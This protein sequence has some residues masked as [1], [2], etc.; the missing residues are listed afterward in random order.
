ADS[1]LRRDHD[2]GETLVFA[3]QRLSAQRR[4]RQGTQLAMPLR[5]ALFVRLRRWP[6]ALVLAAAG[7]SGDSAAR[8]YGR[9]APTRV[10]DEKVLC[11]EVHGFVRA[12]GRDTG[13]LAGS[14]EPE[15]VIEAPQTRACGFARAVGAGWHS[16]DSALVALRVDS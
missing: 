5:L 16:P 1:D 10:P 15:A 7:L 4:A 11:A 12:A 14:A 8:I 2:A 6:G 9:D 13:Q 3:V